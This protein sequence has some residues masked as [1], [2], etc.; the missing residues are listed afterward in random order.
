MNAVLSDSL[1]RQKFSADL[2]KVFL[3]FFLSKALQTSILNDRVLHKFLAS[4]V[5]GLGSLTLLL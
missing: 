2:L 1:G 5:D 4:C 3:L